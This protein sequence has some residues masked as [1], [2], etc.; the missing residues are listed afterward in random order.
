MTNPIFKIKDDDVCQS[1]KFANTNFSNLAAGYNKRLKIWDLKRISNKTNIKPFFEEAIFNGNVD[2]L[3][4]HPTQ[5][6]LLAASK[7]EKIIKILSVKEKVELLLSINLM[8]FEESNETSENILKC[9]FIPGNGIIIVKPKR[10]F[11]FTTMNNYTEAFLDSKF[12]FE[13]PVTNFKTMTNNLNNQY[14]LYTD[15]ENNFIVRLY[16]INENMCKSFLSSSVTFEK[17][18]RGLPTSK[19]NIY[20]KEMENVYFLLNFMDSIELLFYYRY[21]CNFQIFLKEENLSFNYILKYLSCK[22]A[23]KKIPNYFS[24]T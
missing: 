24:I 3:D 19:K 15:K 1:L 2:I 12:D 14:F 23:K 16:T 7:T 10:A 21:L 8:N 5:N 13:Y 11:I 18:T 17:E 22:I 6:F 9:N 20:M 4:W